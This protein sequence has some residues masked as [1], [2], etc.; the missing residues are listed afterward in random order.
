M[1]RHQTVEAGAPVPGAAATGARAV[2]R[3]TMLLSLVGR[4]GDGGATLASLVAGGGLSKATTRRLLLALMRGRLVEQDATSRR[5]R[6]G[7]E[8]FVLGQLARRHDM[9]ALAADS[10]R[11]LSAATGDTSFVSARHGLFVACLH[12]EEGA[13]PV[14]THA[15]KAGDQQPLGV[16]AGSLAILAALPEA[17]RD[18]AIDN[19][20]PDY[21][22]RPGYS[23]DIVRG[24]VARAQ[25]DGHAL[26]PG[27]FVTGSWGIGVPVRYP[28]GCVACALSIAAVDGR[29]GEARRPGIAALIHAEAAVV[30][31]RLADTFRP[32]NQLP[33][34]PNR[35][36]R[37]E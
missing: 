20:A 35:E 13:H 3:A 30:E 29:M 27:R 6:L 28:D 11:R 9:T 14:R 17:E 4:G 34:N 23:A 8:T 36:T 16:G 32:L 24:D 15:L 1:T 26:N 10:L 33:L 12:R 25:R 7:P 5:Y 22:A 31:A 21:A 37:H 19:L 18:A 2:E